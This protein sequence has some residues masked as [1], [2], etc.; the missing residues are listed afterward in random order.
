MLLPTKSPPDA[1]AV[2]TYI[3]FVASRGCVGSA[4]L[5]SLALPKSVSDPGA[6]ESVAG[7]VKS[8]IPN[9]LF[10]T[11]QYV[12]VGPFDVIETSVPLR[13]KLDTREYPGTRLI[14]IYNFPIFLLFIRN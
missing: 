13:S 10:A 3:L 4:M 12:M 7:G 1:N 5:D 2:S 11:S 14:A 9:L 8:P 6:K